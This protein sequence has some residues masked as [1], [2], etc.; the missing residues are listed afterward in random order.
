MDY[1]SLFSANFATLA[2]V[3]LVPVTGV[4]V[5][6]MLARGLGF[7]S[8]P[9]LAGPE[10][11]KALARDAIAGFRPAAAAV[12]A[13]GRAALVAAGDGRVALLRPLGDRW[14][15]RTLERPAVR[16][17]GGRLTVRVREPLFRP[18][19]LDLGPG[20]ADWAE[21]LAA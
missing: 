14:V 10:D 20:A 15:V 8:E 4:T 5:L 1:V 11:A 16:A 17:E 18:V 21:R 2:A 19:T 7:E 13:D 3:F 12:S 9:E 6:V